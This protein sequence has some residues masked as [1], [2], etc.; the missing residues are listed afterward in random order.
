MST[1]MWKIKVP[2]IDTVRE[3]MDVFTWT[4]RRELVGLG[5]PNVVMAA[6]FACYVMERLRQGGGGQGYKAAA[7]A[8]WAAA[9]KSGHKWFKGKN[10]DNYLKGGHNLL[11][12]W[13]LSKYGDSIPPGSQ[14]RLLYTSFWGYLDQAVYEMLF[15]ELEMV[16]LEPNRSE[17]GL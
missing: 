11:R 7:V 1:S 17:W 3:F 9:D 12:R 2:Q 13:V 16:G 8:M 10:K 6:A 15:D 5:H 4:R 14:A